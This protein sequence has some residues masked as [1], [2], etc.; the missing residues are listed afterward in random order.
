[1]SKNCQKIS[2]ILTRIY[3]SGKPTNFGT[4]LS[5][6]KP[7]E[8]LNFQKSAEKLIGEYHKEY[9]ERF[10]FKYMTSDSALTKFLLLPES[11]GF[12]PKKIYS[13]LMNE[14]F[15]YLNEACPEIFINHLNTERYNSFLNLLDQNVE[16]VSAAT[17][18]AAGYGRSE[19]YGASYFSYMNSAFL[20]LF[21]GEET[22]EVDRPL[23]ESI[24]DFFGANLSHGEI[25]LREAGDYA[26][27][28]LNGGKLNI[29]VAGN[30]AGTEM[31][32]GRLRITSECG[33]WPGNRASGGLLEL[34]DLVEHVSG[35][36]TRGFVVKIS[37]TAR[38]AQIKN[39]GAVYWIGEQKRQL[40]ISTDTAIY[41]EKPGAG[42]EY[43]QGK[44]FKP[45]APILLGQPYIKGVFGQPKLFD[46]THSKG[47]IYY[48][49]EEKKKYFSL[50]GERPDMIITN[51]H[52][53]AYAGNQNFAVIKHL[54]AIT[55][56]PFEYMRY[57]IVVMYDLPE[58]DIGKGMRGG[59]L[60]LEEAGATVESIKK[61]LFP[62]RN[63]GI[64]FLRVSDPDNPGKTK[65]VDVEG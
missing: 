7:Q 47:T 11:S 50:D 42:I 59:I 61:R 8:L 33:I 12:D 55:E 18:K 19:I 41:I 64:I 51:E 57:G 54:Q 34:P 49:D 38:P 46:K 29:C 43:F 4:T 36:A 13:E 6:P 24:R 52:L 44:A 45:K 14:A 21:L 3:Q 28:K 32:R 63:K 39:G 22:V 27:Y 1:M 40:G 26:G 62:Y 5:S 25:S 20:E 31:S 35:G 56:N 37:K 15:V 65:L 9:F 60:I 53:I 23:P 58:R 2:N 48:F 16:L 17:K 10:F 30:Q